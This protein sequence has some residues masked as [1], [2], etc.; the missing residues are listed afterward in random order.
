MRLGVAAGLVLAGHA[1]QCVARFPAVLN[2]FLRGSRCCED[3]AVGAK[4]PPSEKLLDIAIFRAV[5]WWPG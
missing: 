2:N 3:I 4:W 5:P 1:S